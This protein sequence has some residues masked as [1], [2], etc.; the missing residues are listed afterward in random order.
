MRSKNFLVTSEMINVR[1]LESVKLGGFP[2]QIL[3]K[4]ES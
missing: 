1:E 2:F 4:S 3:I